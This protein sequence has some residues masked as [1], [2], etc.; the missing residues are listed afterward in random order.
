MSV[1]TSWL[2]SPPRRADRRLARLVAALCALTL[3]ALAALALAVPAPALAE[4]TQVAH[5]ADNNTYTD[6][7]KAWD[8]ALAGKVVYMDADWHRSAALGVPSG[9]SATLKM[10]GHKVYR[11]YVESKDGCIF[12][13]YENSSLTLDGSGFSTDFTVVGLNGLDA[14]G[15]FTLTSG[16][17]VTGGHSNNS[18]GAIE[19]KEGSYL[20]LVNVAVAGNKAYTANGGAV[21]TDGKNCTIEMEN[22]QICCNA[23]SKYGGGVYINN[24]D[25]KIT[26]TTS[27]ISYNWSCGGGGVYSDSSNTVITMKEKSHIDHNTDCSSSYGGGGV[28]FNSSSFTLTGRYGASISFNTTNGGRGGAVATANS[29]GGNIY[30]I[31]FESNKAPKDKAGALYLDSSNVRVESCSFTTNE[32]GDDGGAIYS[33][34]DGVYLT[35]C[36]FT[37]NSSGGDGGAVY[38]DHSSWRVNGCSVWSNSCSERGGGFYVNASNQRM[39]STTIVN[40]TAGLEGGGIFVYRKY[41]VEMGYAMCVYGNTRGPLEGGNADDVF[42]DD[43]GGYKAYINWVTWTGAPNSRVGFRTG[44]TGERELVHK[45]LDYL[46][47]YFFLDQGDSYHLSM[48]DNT[49][50]QVPGAVRYKV[51]VN[52][53]LVDEYAYGAQVTVD[54]SE[55]AA[56]TEAFVRWDAGASTGLWNPGDVLAEY[57]NPVQTFSE[58]GTD[59]NLSAVY[60]TRLTSG[61]IKF[62]ALEPGGDLPSTATLTRP[63]GKTLQVSV[64]WAKVTEQG[65]VA[66]TGTVEYGTT[67]VATVQAAQDTWEGWAYALSPDVSTFTLQVGSDAKTNQAASASTDGQTGALTVVSKPMTT[68][69]KALTSLDS[70]EAVQI[71]AGQTAEALAAAMPQS[72]TGTVEGGSAVEL[73][74]NV[75]DIDWSTCV[76]ASGNTVLD[77]QGNVAE[78]GNDED[79]RT[80]TVAVAVVAPEGL[81]VPESLASVTV[82]VVVSHADLTVTFNLGDGSGTTTSTTVE[83]GKT[84]SAPTVSDWEGR[85]FLGWYAQGASSAY[86]FSTPVKSNLTLTGTWALKEYTVTF[87]ASGAQP[88]RQTVTVKWGEPVGGPTTVPVRDSATLVGWYVEGSGAAYDL[89][90]PVTSNLTLVA[91]WTHTVTF[92]YGNGQDDVVVEVAD[93]KA[94]ARPTDPT[95]EN[96]VFQGWHLEGSDA[97]YS[98]SWPVTTNLILKAHWSWVTYQV[99][100]NADGGSPQPAAQTVVTGDPATD[101]G[102]PTQDHATFLGWFADGA[103]TAWD[104]TT[105]IVANVSLT[106]HWSYDTCTLTFDPAN[107]EE[108]LKVQVRYG[109]TAGV[110][111]K[112]ERTGYRFDWWY[113]P[114]GSEWEPDEPVTTD[115]T[116]TAAWIQLPPTSFVDVEEGSWYEGWVNLAARM[117]FMQG[118]KDE[119]GAYTGYF[120]PN[121]NITRG[122]V[123]VVLWR[124][125]GRPDPEEESSPFADVSDPEAYYYEAVLWCYERGIV[126]GYLAGERAGTFCPDAEVT[127]EELAVMI[128]RFASKIGRIDTSDASTEAF[129]ACLDKDSVS[130]WAHDALVWCASV[131]VM[132]GKDIA[133][134]GKRLDP[135]ENATRAQAAKVF[136]RF[137]IVVTEH[138]PYQADGTAEQAAAAE[139][140]E[141]TFDDVATFE[142]VGEEQAAGETSGEVTGEQASADDSAPAFDDVEF[143]QAA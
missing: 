143:D 1:P 33:A 14:R 45:V 54:A 73:A 129:D 83:W 102:A 106:A 76:D 111:D 9:K 72:V 21:R 25:S 19:M 7:D 124:M 23:S 15:T 127:R 27:S 4:D 47:C 46:P 10:C 67:Y 77:E 136:V 107:G 93:G 118:Y 5:D 31:T 80:C 90:T 92:E 32:S 125:V 8:A 114:D 115:L 86:V 103:E 88:E 28:Y 57:K 69:L 96:H 94:V 128:A 140:Q 87:V 55:L 120:G 16:G 63:D 29:D 58:P 34:G 85:D 101:P 66:V 40:N 3:A 60:M 139:A 126:T 6:I 26:M 137:W 68:R 38:F 48:S 61:S 84:V 12:W 18:G 51:S 36:N 78:P 89:K 20:K 123:A 108:P 131:D 79:A 142:P 121:D 134:G 59:V 35:G 97:S 122:Q 17:L 132:S 117:N 109:Q 95:W 119:T 42:L 110:P 135:Q 91:D 82:E 64:A 98:F 130:L 50:S 133:E 99:T 53:T 74:L 113:L 24:A 116:L 104:F 52:G 65:N 56:D 49:L 30:G 62:G 70:L 105:P 81:D 75:A 41:D 22:A 100:F 11:D 141:A 2:P 37:G 44:T 71:K 39:V 138:S 43:G 13:L 112:P